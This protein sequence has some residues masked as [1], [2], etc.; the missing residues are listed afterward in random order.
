MVEKRQVGLEERL[1]R[2]RTGEE[3][4]AS[5]VLML[6][7]RGEAIGDDEIA[8]VGASKCVCDTFRYKDRQ[9]TEVVVRTKVV[10]LLV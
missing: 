6:M 9:I 3:E 8:I 5:L 10:L 2:A 7:P 4:A 1:K